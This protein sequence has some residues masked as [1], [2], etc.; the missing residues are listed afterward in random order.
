MR[1]KQRNRSAYAQ[2]IAIGQLQMPGHLSE[3]ID[4]SLLSQALILL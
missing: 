2:K 1:L 3:L 4:L